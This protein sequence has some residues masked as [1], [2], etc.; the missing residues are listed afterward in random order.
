MHR[1]LQAKDMQQGIVSLW[2]MMTR[3]LRIHLRQESSAI[4]K[5]AV[6]ALFIQKSPR[7]LHDAMEELRLRTKQ[8]STSFTIW[9]EHDRL[10]TSG[11]IQNL[12]SDNTRRTRE[13]QLASLKAYGEVQDI[14][15]NDMSHVMESIYKLVQTSDNFPKL[16]RPS[17]KWKCASQ[18]LSTRKYID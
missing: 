9:I 1:A 7:E 12:L 11:N 15:K 5:R 3:T 10:T 14:I 8:L 6:V 13:A 16:E 18:T 2:D 4:W 17:D